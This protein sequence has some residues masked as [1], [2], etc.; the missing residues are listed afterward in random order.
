VPSSL[1]CSQFARLA[2]LE[3]LAFLHIGSGDWSDFREA[4]RRLPR[5]IHSLSMLSFGS[6]DAEV[7]E[8]D[9]GRGLSNGPV[10]EPWGR[11]R[12]DCCGVEDFPPGLQ[13]GEWLLRYTVGRGLS[14]SSLARS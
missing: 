7:W 6:E 14:E 3:H 9:R 1:T 10:L 2:Q 13:D 11:A 8:I 5:D 12:I 4:A